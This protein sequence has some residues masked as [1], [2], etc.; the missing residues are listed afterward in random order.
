[1]VKKKQI[2]LHFSLYVFRQ[3]EA[4]SAIFYIW[5]RQMF[6]EFNPLVISDSFPPPA[7]DT[8]VKR[9]RLHNTYVLCPR[10]CVVWYG[11]PTHPT[12]GANMQYCVQVSRHLIQSLS[13]PTGSQSKKFVYMTL[14]FPWSKTV[15][16][17]RYAPKRLTHSWDICMSYK[18]LWRANNNRPF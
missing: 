15:C 2:S 6:T 17:N 12:K 9:T 8:R 18:N 16:D 5:R 10:I 14:M 3:D 13:V 1:M 11:L 4:Q 7:V